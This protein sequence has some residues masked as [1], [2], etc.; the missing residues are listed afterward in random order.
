MSA[1]SATCHPRLLGSTKS[2]LYPVFLRDL[3]I[4]IIPEIG[5]MSIGFP[6]VKIRI[7]LAF[8]FGRWIFLVE[9]VVDNEYDYAFTCF[10][11]HVRVQAD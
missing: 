3:V 5:E 10:S 6:W 1:Y 2:T 4:V 8:A 9:I 7:W 11:A